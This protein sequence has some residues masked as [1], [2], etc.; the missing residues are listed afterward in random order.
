FCIINKLGKRSEYML[1]S[2]TRWVLQEQD[3]NIINEFTEQLK[4]TSLVAKLL[5]NRG[6]ETVED[7]RSFL[8]IEEA[9]F[10]DPFLFEGMSK[11]VARIKQAI[12]ENEQILI[13]GDYDADGVTSTAIMMTV[14]ND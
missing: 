2:K 10:H 12:D 11:A 5:L 13:Y 14:L 8:H 1:H 4:I 6:I 7:A 9:T 3:E